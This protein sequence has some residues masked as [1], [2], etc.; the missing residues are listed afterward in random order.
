MFLQRLVNDDDIGFNYHYMGSS[1][2]EHG[3]TTVA[4]EKLARLMI[5]KQIGGKKVNLTEKWGRSLNGPI[6]VWVFG[7]KNYIA[8]LGTRGSTD[9]IVGDLTVTTHKSSA[10]FDDPKILGWMNVYYGEPLL[11]VRA[12]QDNIERGNKFLQAFMDLI[13]TAE[14]AP[15]QTTGEKSEAYLNGWADA[16]ALNRR[17]NPYPECSPEFKDY[18]YGYTLSMQEND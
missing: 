4:R 5:D 15:A 14:P 2:F 17:N 16:S 11:I 8:D 9:P 3:S 7:D 18:D 10:R 1:E 13:L 12:T 6:E